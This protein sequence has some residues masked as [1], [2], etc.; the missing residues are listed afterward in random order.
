MRRRRMAD[1]L[2]EVRLSRRGLFKNSLLVG[3]GAVGLSGASAALVPG[4]ARAAASDGTFSANYNY[5]NQSTGIFYF[6][7]NWNYCVNCRCIFYAPDNHSGSCPMTGGYHGP[8]TSPSN[9]GIVIDDSFAV[10]I[11][12]PAYLQSPWRWCR[13]CNC[14]YWGNAQSESWCTHN[15]GGQ[16]NTPHS[17]SG[18]GVYY[19]PYGLEANGSA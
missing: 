10:P 1:V 19:M 9:Y 7:L 6:Q 3:L 15:A 13:N 18:S 17:S 2:P 4:I 5:P 16:T 11:V 14:L 8:G 12:A